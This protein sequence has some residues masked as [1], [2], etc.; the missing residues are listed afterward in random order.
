MIDADILAAL[1]RGLHLAATLSLLGTAGFRAWIL[2]GEAPPALHRRLMR[3]WWMNG[4]V[5]LLAGSAWFT[6]QAALVAGAQNASDV[7]AALPAVATHTRYGTMLVL[8]LTLLLAALVAGGC[9]AGPASQP[10]TH[11][12]PVFGRFHPGT[13]AS[14]VLTAIALC[15]QGYMGHAGATAGAIGGALML[16]VSLHL[17]AAGLWLG[18]LIPLCISLRWLPP[19]CSVSVCERF[20]PIGLA[21]VLILAGTGLAQ[22]LVLIGSVPSLFGT[23]YGH[24]ALLKIA[25]FLVAL[26]LAAANRLWLTDRLASGSANAAKYLRTSIGF[27]ALIGLS[28][29]VAASFLASAVP[30][31]HE[32]KRPTEADGWWSR[33]ARSAAISG[34]CYQPVE[35][36]PDRKE[37]RDAIRPRFAA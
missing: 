9:G 33:E 35:L 8:R 10:R 28:I 27:E 31:T 32:V 3:L 13:A 7:W 21:C 29:V 22:G 25:L 18:A 16:S 34:I 2:P 36:L 5:A 14:M 6:L 20:S 30:G 17:L 26:A 24:I 4:A 23:R 1:M 37:A 11:A 19:A 15:L 12:V